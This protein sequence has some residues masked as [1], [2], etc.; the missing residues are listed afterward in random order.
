MEEEIISVFVD[1][2]VRYIEHIP[3]IN[4]LVGTP[5][6]VE[7]NKP[8]AYDIT[9]IIGITGVRK[10]CVYFTSPKIFLSHLL[11]A[12]EE[13]DTSEEN[14]FDLA[15][16]IANT[17][18]GNARSAFGKDFMISVPVIVKGAPSSVYLPPGLRSYA[19]P[20][21]W[22]SYTPVLLVSLEKP[23]P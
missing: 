7:N 23:C 8:I 15:G 4:A 2:M 6:L 5:Y 17:I 22:Q 3:N 13:S 12:Q 16:E 14:L 11:L 19:I 1:G 20:I 21:T 9:G 18:S 10:G